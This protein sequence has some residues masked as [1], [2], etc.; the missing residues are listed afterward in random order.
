[1]QTGKAAMILSN[2]K[3]LSIDLQDYSPRGVGVQ[4]KPGLARSAYVREEVHFK[5]SWNPRLFAQGRYII[6]NIKGDR[7][8]V[9]NVAYRGWN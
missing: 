4:T 2:G 1:M 9:E 7:I 3:E 6:R 8:G 5:C